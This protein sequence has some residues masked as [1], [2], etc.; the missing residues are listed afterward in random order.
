MKRNKLQELQSVIGKKPRETNL[1]KEVKSE[2]SLA[3]SRADKV[4]IYAWLSKDYKR[5][6][7]MIQVNHDRSMQSLIAEG[8]NHVFEKYNVPTVDEE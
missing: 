2:S 5:S 1:E 6:I 3:P 4:P 8:L 7:R